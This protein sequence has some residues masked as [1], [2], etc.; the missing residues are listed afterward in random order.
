MNL[1]TPWIGLWERINISVFLLWIVMLAA[2]LWRSA[3]AKG[4]DP[5]GEGR[6]VAVGGAS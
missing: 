6:Y 4:Q 3:T 5:E 1:P 2:V